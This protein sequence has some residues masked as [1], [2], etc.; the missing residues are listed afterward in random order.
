MGRTNS[1]SNSGRNRVKTPSWKKVA[2]GMEAWGWFTEY[3][4]KD[5]MIV[6]RGRQRIIARKISNTSKWKVEY[7]SG[8]IMD[9]TTG[10]ESEFFA[11]RL[12]AEMAVL[13]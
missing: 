10:A 12:A 4:D 9:D 11:K 5:K 2:K 13:K 1:H 7:F 6:E 8:R 3:I